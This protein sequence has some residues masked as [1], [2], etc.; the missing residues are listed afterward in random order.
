MITG[1]FLDSFEYYYMTWGLLNAFN[2]IARDFFQS[3]GS[4]L[5]VLTSRRGKKPFHSVLLVFFFYVSKNVVL[6]Y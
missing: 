5:S 2:N 4:N 3:R 1:V 6:V